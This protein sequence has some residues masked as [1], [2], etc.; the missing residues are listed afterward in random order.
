MLTDSE[1][2]TIDGLI[3]PARRAVEALEAKATGVWGWIV[4]DD[5]HRAASTAR[6]MYDDAI[7]AFTTAKNSPDDQSQEALRI[8]DRLRN[9]ISPGYVEG[10]IAT[11][12]AGEVT[13]GVLDKAGAFVGQGLRKLGID[14]SGIATWV[15]IAIV[16]IGLLAVAYIAGIAVPF[17][18]RRRHA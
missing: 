14:P 2:Q 3:D 12:T 7:V 18:P 10:A 6:T 9:L 15:K 5:A 4:R 17:I 16:V 8:V 11:P 13:A 1:I